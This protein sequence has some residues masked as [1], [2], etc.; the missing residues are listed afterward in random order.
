MFDGSNRM[1]PHHARACI[2]HGFTHLLLHIWLITMDG[3]LDLWSSLLTLGKG[4][5]VFLCSRLIATFL[6]VG[7]F[8][9]N[10]Q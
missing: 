5:R 9:P 6:Q 8:S 7:F 10:L 4:K 3:A 1:I 2:A